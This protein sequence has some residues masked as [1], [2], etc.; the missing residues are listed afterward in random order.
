MP[1][2]SDVTCGLFHFIIMV[3]IE[4]LFTFKNLND[5]FYECFSANSK[6]HSNRVYYNGLLFNN[7][8]LMDDLLSRKYRISPSSHATI[9][10]RGKRREI[11]SPVMRDRIVQKIIC[12]KVFVKQL[13]PKFIY[14]NYSSVEKRG[15]TMA[16]KRFENM[17]Y[18]FLRQ[19][20]YDIEHYGFILV[21]DVK[22]FFNNID[23]EILK[24]MLAEDL[25]VS[26]DLLRLI[27][28]LI[29]E[30]SEGSKGLNLGSELPQILAMYYLSKMDNYIKCCMGVKY[31]GR[32]ADD[33][34]VIAK[35]KEELYK[36]L[37]SI[38][39]QLSKVKL[40]INVKKT[41]IIKI[42]HGFTYLQT[43]Y[44]VIK[45]KGVYK[46]LKMPTR[47]KITRERKRI[48]AHARQVNVEKLQYREVYYW[49]KAYKKSLLADYNAVDKTIES[50][51][52]I[53]DGLFE[54]Y[55]LPRK[56]TRTEVL[57]ERRLKWKK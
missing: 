34:I 43:N 41:N 57:L 20:D 19:I 26:D 23:H 4:E 24:S 44:K 14:D 21:A 6:K 51:D 32:Y 10:E 1:D 47:A 38:E 53:F 13:V 18:E 30:S 40:K 42:K 33:I 39:W 16:R 52:D 28:Y 31:Y 5:A 50:L 46:V 49:Y 56:P 7:L 55:E 17:L 11:D 35:T 37:D 25:D 12:Q 2:K 45:K 27:F 3:T 54:G 36:V 15:T 48:K 8:D 9:V 29:D 22:E